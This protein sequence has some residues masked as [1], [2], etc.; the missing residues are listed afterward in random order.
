MTEERGSSK[1]NF[2]GKKAKGNMIKWKKT[3]LIIRPDPKLFWC[4][5]HAMIPTPYPIGDGVY[6]IYFSGR[7]AQNQSHIGFA[8]VSLRGKLEV[9]NIC[10]KPVLSPGKLGCFDDNGVTPSCV[11]RINSRE[12]ALYFIGWN[13]GS[14]TRMNLFGGLAISRDRGETFQRWS[15][16]PILER[17]RCDPLINTAPWV[18]KE[19]QR[20]RMFYVSGTE[21]K[22]KDLPRYNIKTC[23]SRDGKSWSRDGKVAI[24]FKNNQENAL[25]RPYVLKEKSLWRMWF[26]HKGPAYRLGYAE[27]RDGLHWKRNDLIANLKPSTEGFDSEMIEYAAVVKYKGR[28]FMFYNGNN[29]GR[30]GIGLA[31]EEACG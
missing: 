19:G 22:H 1:P 29:Y 17:C 15:D 3:G 30:E 26:S 20:Y 23:L 31:V 2:L 28:H 8:T 11:L 12:L 4:K 25:A 5:T 18:V 13:P 24:N 14:T 21:W 9:L 27:S 7:N 16:A 6:K 10:K